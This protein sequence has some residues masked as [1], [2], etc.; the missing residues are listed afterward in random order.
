MNMS[1]EILSTFQAHLVSESSQRAVSPASLQS[2]DLEGRGDDHL[3]LLVVGGRDALER[4]KPLEGL[5]AAL[6][7]V[8]LTR[9]YDSV[10]TSHLGLCFL[11]T[12][13]RGT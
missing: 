9:C 13:F 11:I 2:E 4:L 10:S 7:L 3:L 1:C 12:L 8:R 5:L 6:G